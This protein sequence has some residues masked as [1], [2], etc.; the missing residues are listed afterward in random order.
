MRISRAL[1]LLAFLYL[2][3]RD[4]QAQERP[5]GLGIEIGAPTGL[6]GKLYMNKPFA[7]QFGVGY[8][9]QFRAAEGLHLHIEAVWHPVV[10]AHADA[11]DMPFYFGVGG[12]ILQHHWN[13]SRDFDEDDT[14]IGVRVPF[15][16]LMDFNSVPID[17]FFE[18]AL[19]VDLIVI[20]DYDDDVWDHDLV[21]LNGALGIRYYF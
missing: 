15:G 5:F 21:D 9:A 8:M 11:F 14:H 19:I 12:R 10:L 20:D 17:I 1:A 3:P 16:L 2:I 6:A 13:R 18:L 4:V 7:L